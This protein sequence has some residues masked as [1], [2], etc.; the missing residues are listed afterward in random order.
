MDDEDFGNDRDPLL[1]RPFLA[2][3]D[4][5]EG[6]S[7]TTSEATWPSGAASDSATQVLPVFSGA[8]EAESAPRRRKRRMLLVAGLGAVVVIVLA[9]AGYSAL[10]PDFAP[11]LSADLPGP[12][13]PVVTGPV[14]ASPSAAPGAPDTT[15]G[16]DDNSGSGNAG[17]TS[18]RTEATTTPKNTASFKTVT[19]ASVAPSAVASEPANAPALAP[20]PPKVGTGALVSGN[21]LCLDLPNAIPFDDNVIQVFDCNRTVAQVWTL[22]DD[23]T[24]R[25]MGKCALLVGDNT[26]HLTGCDHRT[27]AQWRV[28]DGQSLVNAANNQCL[29]DPSDGARPGTRVMVVKCTGRSNQNWSMK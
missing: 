22:A 20:S 4:A 19:P 16:G 3:D 11:S 29:T 2:Q 6:H 24:L 27:T 25:V 10:R 12:S 23:G 13:F 14:S 17:G 26:V 15:S 9:A 5:P 21:G 28:G 1:V 18:G 8:A 7:H